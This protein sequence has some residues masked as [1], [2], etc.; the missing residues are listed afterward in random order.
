M[1]ASSCRVTN[2]TSLDPLLSTNLLAHSLLLEETGKVR[3]LGYEEN[4]PSVLFPCGAARVG[5]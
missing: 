2:Q 5:K 1:G 3:I 4:F